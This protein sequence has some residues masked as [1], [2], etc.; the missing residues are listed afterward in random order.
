MAPVAQLAVLLA[1]LFAAVGGASGLEAAAPAPAPLVARLDAAFAGLEGSVQQ[2]S[3]GVGGWMMECWSA[4]TELR[5]CTNEIVLFFLSGDSFVSRDC[6][7]I[8][9]TITRHC[10]PAMLASVGFT[11]EEAGILRGFCDAEVGGAHAPPAT[12]LVPPTAPAPAQAR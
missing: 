6:C 12:P 9:R 2:P 10:W 5:S 3:D 1:L 4:V 11:A 7:L 8:I